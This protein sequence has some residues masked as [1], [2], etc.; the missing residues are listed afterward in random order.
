MNMKNSIRIRIGRSTL[1]IKGEGQTHYHRRAGT[2]HRTIGS[3]A[4]YES[5]GISLR[6]PMLTPHA[7]RSDFLKETETPPFLVGGRVWVG[8]S[9]RSRWI[10]VL[11][12][13]NRVTEY[14][15]KIF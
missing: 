12:R 5:R 2:Q 14:C 10:D 4:G 8:W 9:H 11:V 13:L 1:S 3:E 7:L 15:F 6:I